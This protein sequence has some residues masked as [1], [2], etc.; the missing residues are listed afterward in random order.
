MYQLFVYFQPDLEPDALQTALETCT[1]KLDSHKGSVHTEDKIKKVSLAYPIQKKEFAYAWMSQ[2][3][4]PKDEV[5]EFESYLLQN[6]DVLRHTLTKS[7]PPRKVAASQKRQSRLDERAQ[8][9]AASK[10]EETP[11]VVKE[12]STEI[13]DK[14]LEVAE[15]TETEKPKV[16]S[17]EIEK[18]LDDLLKGKL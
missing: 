11:S 3:E 10:E 2:I 14:E 9:N 8:R 1:K 7:T 5:A 18:K 12:V 4:V 16:D 15:S 13:S 6:G 17:K